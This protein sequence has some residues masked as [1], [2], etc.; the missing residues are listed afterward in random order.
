[1]ERGEFEALVVDA[2]ANLPAE[3]QDQLE[4]VDVVVEERPTRRQL[5]RAGLGRGWSLLGLYEGVPQTKRTRAYSMVLPDRITLFQGPIEAKCR[6]QE[7]IAEE[8][9]R[10]L[11]HEIAHHFGI[12]EDSLRR[13]EGRPTQTQ[14][15]VKWIVT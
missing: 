6:S 11:L 9:K 2:L 4:N 15:E 5:S 12:D 14:I 1:M 8:I 10:V 13:I 3:F 7:E